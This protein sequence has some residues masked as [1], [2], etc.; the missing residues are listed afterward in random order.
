[1]ISPERYYEAHLKGKTKE[2]IMIAIQ[3][4]KQ[5]MNRIKNSM[6]NPYSG[7]KTVMHPSE[8]TRIFGP[9]NI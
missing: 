7:I 8:D 1:M 4:L 5:E 3:G 2:Q 9:V 6:E